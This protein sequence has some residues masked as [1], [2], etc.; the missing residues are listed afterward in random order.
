MYQLLYK[1]ATKC[2]FVKNNLKKIY[3]FLPRKPEWRDG[4]GE[5]NQEAEDQGTGTDSRESGLSR[6]SQLGNES[7]QICS[8]LA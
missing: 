2:L 3:C 5:V 1:S 7:F 4:L 6:K 8:S